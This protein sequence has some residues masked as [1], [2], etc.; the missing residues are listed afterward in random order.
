MNKSNPKA[1]PFVKWAGGKRSLLPQ[2]LP[3]APEKFNKY[4]EPFVGG[5]AVFF[6]LADK[7]HGGAI[8]DINEELL[9]T[10]RIIRNQPDKLVK[11]LEEHRKN[12]FEWMKQ[13][14][15]RLRKKLKELNVSEEDYYKLKKASK[16]KDKKE[17]LATSL[18][19]I[20]QDNKTNLTLE[21][22]NPIV[23]TGRISES[24]KKKIYFYKI[25]DEE[26]TNDLDVAARF[27]YLN[28]TC[29]NGLH[30]VNAA[31]KFNV[32]MGDYSNPDI[33]REKEI[34]ATSEALQHI[35]EIV[36]GDFEKIKPS[37]GDF[38]YFDPP[39]DALN[40]GSFT[41]YAK[42]DFTR[43]DQKRL[44]DFSEELTNKGVKVMLSNHD[45][46]FIRRLYKDFNIYKIQVNR[47]INSQSGGRGKVGEVLIT[48]YKPVKEPTMDN[49][50]V[51]LIN[52][53]ELKEAEELLEGESKSLREGSEKG[54]D[55]FKLADLIDSII[56]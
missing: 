6:A 42:D 48:N 38:V 35:D 52:S 8:G 21:D 14:K 37:K 16:G 17:N 13:D 49:G 25:R 33:V 40:P 24:E 54:S 1:Q 19:A 41:Q 10:Y 2:I 50:E 55:K 31:G 5:G 29:F 18:K 9:A 7:A 3:A 56:K 23:N 45:T 47:P 43:F 30:R 51:G 53:K 32:P 22:I 39:Y 36:Y 34:K 44:K 4:Y 27:I 12:H 28:R 11:K 26:P 46:A 20:N 15:A